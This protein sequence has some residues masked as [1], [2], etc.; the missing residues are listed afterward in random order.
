M[1]ERSIK[2]ELSFQQFGILRKSLNNF[3][4]IT[5][6]PSVGLEYEMGIDQIDGSFCI[7]SISDVG[8]D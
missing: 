8:F 1:L 4:R 7:R 2:G 5:P 3:P 6:I